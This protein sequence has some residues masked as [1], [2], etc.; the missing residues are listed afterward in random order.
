MKL[1]FLWML[2]CISGAVSG[3]TVWRCG[4]DGRSYSN[5][6]C[7]EGRAL[8]VAVARPAADLSSAREIAQREQALG[9]RLVR[10]RQQRQAEVPAGAGLA[11]IHGS[12]LTQ[13]SGATVVAMKKPRLKRKPGLEESG[14]SRAVGPSTRPRQG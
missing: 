7:P 4:S 11:G 10:E 2:L 5:T 14:T 9:A 6:P 12:R 13:P 8:E 3:Q 1:G